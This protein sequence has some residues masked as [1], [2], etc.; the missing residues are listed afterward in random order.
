MRIHALPHIYTIY[1]RLR[2]EVSPFNI[3]RSCDVDASSERTLFLLLFLFSAGFGWPRVRRVYSSLTVFTWL[4]LALIFPP[5]LLV[6]VIFALLANVTE[7]AHVP[8]ASVVVEEEQQE[9]QQRTLSQQERRDRARLLCLCLVRKSVDYQVVSVLSG[10]RVN[11]QARPSHTLF[12]NTNLH[13]P[14]RHRCSHVA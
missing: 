9:G 3:L 1:T 7:E 6:F 5:L 14:T 12:V 8:T 2:K 4:F 10:W 11:D 13:E